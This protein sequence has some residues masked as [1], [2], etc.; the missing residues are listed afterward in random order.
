M[1]LPR[2]TQDSTLRDISSDT[3]SSSPG[4]HWVTLRVFK[5]GFNCQTSFNS[6]FVIFPIKF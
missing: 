2:F 1:I 5:F 6:G 3:F 4:L